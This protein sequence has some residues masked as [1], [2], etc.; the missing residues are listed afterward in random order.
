M[1]VQILARLVAAMEALAETRALVSTG[2][3]AE[4]TKQE[5]PDYFRG[6]GHFVREPTHHAEA[7]TSHLFDLLDRVGR[8]EIVDLC[9]TR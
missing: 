8:N 5:V 3:L 4:L 6:D 9:P 1:R 2:S 7:T